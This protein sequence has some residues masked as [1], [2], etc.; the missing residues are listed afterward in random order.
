M[1][2]K[3]ISTADLEFQYRGG[4]PGYGEVARAV[5]GDLS[6]TIAA[7]LA[8]F[9]ACSIAWTVLYDEVVF[10][11]QGI[12][13]LVTSNGTLEGHPGD[14]IWIPEGTELKYEGEGATIFYVVYPGNWKEIHGLS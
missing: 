6:D 10:V 14:V 5:G 1:S 13:R 7:G 4:P 9:D 8:R 2:A 12:F 3:L 11:H